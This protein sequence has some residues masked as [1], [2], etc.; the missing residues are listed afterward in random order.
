MTSGARKSLGR[1]TSSWSIRRRTVG[2]VLIVALVICLLAVIAFFRLR[3]AGPP[4][5]EQQDLLL[6]T[7]ESVGKV[8][9][10]AKAGDIHAQSTLGVAHLRG[11]EHVPKN[12]TAAVYW[13][14]RIADRD[15]AEHDQVVGRMRSLLEERR[16]T[17]N[18]E[19]QRRLELEYL[20]LV[21]K[22]L[23]FELAFVGLI[24]VY[25]GGHGSSY[26]NPALARRYMRQGAAY[27]FAS[28]QRM[29]GMAYLFG[30]LDVPRNTSQGLKL[31]H[32]AAAQGDRAAEYLLADWY[33]WGMVVPANADAARYWF[34]RTAG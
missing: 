2:L 22:K 28:A 24:E 18:R 29:L 6:L 13:F 27:G 12:V 20:G 31:L 17:T 1:P 32:A 34:G 16:L 10:A 3:A 14:H 30:L 5:P 21:Q 26:A 4:E 9:A 25:S 33:R 15:R 11:S 8:E 19:Q 23:A 7:P